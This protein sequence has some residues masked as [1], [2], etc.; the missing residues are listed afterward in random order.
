VR[1]PKPSFSKRQVWII[2]NPTWRGHN[3]VRDGFRDPYI[4]DILIL[5][6][7]VTLKGPISFAVQSPLAILKSFSGPDSGSSSGHTGYFSFCSGQF[8]C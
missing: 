3:N 5:A 4:S 2:D 1:W 8:L 7:V 6:S